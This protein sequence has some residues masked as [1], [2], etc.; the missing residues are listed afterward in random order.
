VIVIAQFWAFAG[1]LLPAGQ[2]K[3]VFWI[4]GFGGAAGAWAGAWFAAHWFPAFG[5]CRMML[6]AAALLFGSMLLGLRAARSRPA[7][8]EVEDAADRKPQKQVPSA[9]WKRY[10][11]W[12]A[13]LTIL[14]NVVSSTGEYIFSK[15]VMIE[16]D[17]VAGS[18]PQAEILKQAFVGQFYARFF[19]WANFLGLLLQLVCVPLILRRLCLP[20]SLFILPAVMLAGYGALAA[21]PLLGL[22]QI[23]RLLESGADHSIQTTAVHA[24]FLPAGRDLKYQGTVV[25]ET[26]FAR[27]GD[28]LHALLIFLGSRFSLS[29]SAYA[30]INLALA[31]AALFLVALLY[32][33]NRKSAVWS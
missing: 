25:L 28:L 23:A 14:M 30:S 9:Q 17:R 15:L 33:E 20:A 1:D 24:L 29:V 7:A 22:V 19:G 4:M 21:V 32:R 12:I 18:G 2:G 11:L 10:L 5:P 13:L 31:V 26:V 27:L 3:R 8:A 6:L 16:A